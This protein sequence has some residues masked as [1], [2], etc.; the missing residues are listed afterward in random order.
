MSYTFTEIKKNVYL[1]EAETQYDLCSMFVRPQEFYESPFDNIQGKYFS[2]EEFMDTYAKSKGDFTYFNDWSGF[3]FPCWVFHRFFET[4]RYDLREKEIILRQGIMGLHSRKNI[5]EKFYV[6]G[7]LKGQAR[8]INHEVAHAYWH[9]YPEY[10][11]KMKTL[12]A[13][14]DDNLFELA[15]NSLLAQGYCEATLMDELQAYLATTKKRDQLLRYFN[16]TEVKNVRVPSAFR[17]YFDE[18]TLTHK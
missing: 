3:N 4:F 15:C 11:E 12:I 13:T 8:V 7:S 5:A 9:F 1:V 10:Q 2:L 6:I 14:L 18:F 16:W 17:K